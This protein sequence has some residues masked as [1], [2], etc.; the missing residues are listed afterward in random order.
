MVDDPFNYV[1]SS[2]RD[3]LRP[4]RALVADMDAVRR[5]LTINLKHLVRVSD[6]KSLS[7]VVQ[8]VKCVTS[9]ALRSENPACRELG[10]HFWGKRY[11]FK[12]VPRQGINMVRQYIRNQKEK[13]A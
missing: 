5:Y 9:A 1:W 10:E 7:R 6:R 11:G 2:Y 8:K 4:G 12:I 13:H 3:Y